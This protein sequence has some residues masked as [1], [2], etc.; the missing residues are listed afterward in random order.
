[1]TALVHH[2]DHFVVPVDD[3]VTAERFYPAVFGCEIA[4]DG[5]GK[6]MRLGMSAKERAA[7]YA[8]HTFFDIAGTRIGVYLQSEERA[9]AASAHGA[10]TYSLAVTPNGINDALLELERWGTPYDRP[11]PG[12]LFFADP[13][14]NWF[15]LTATEG[16]LRG[17]GARVVGIGNLQL[18]APDLAAS[19]R[20]YE[21]AFGLAAA[22]Y[23]ASPWCAAREATLTLPS[24]QRLAL[25]E[26]PFA[27][28]GLVL[29]HDVAGPH[30]AFCAPRD[31]WDA[32][33]ECLTSLGLPFA[34]RG[35]ELK[36][37]AAERR[38]AYVA[39]PAGNVLQLLS[40]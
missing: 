28:K 20:F 30:L 15:H 27:S 3:I 37:R 12:D 38:D 2:F 10:P 32:L 14:G 36:H 23:G 35:A 6:P 13:A 24:G 11:R 9:P 40:Y 34:D 18:E 1:V 31:R 5:T 16:E 25:T 7:G 22:E 39:D 33:C 8:P 19:V 29:R 26:L 21:R 4:C 17:S